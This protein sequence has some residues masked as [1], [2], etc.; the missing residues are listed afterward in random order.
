MDQD[1]QPTAERLATAYLAIRDAIAQ[2]NRAAEREIKKLKA[3]QDRIS[4][5]LNKLCDAMDCSSIKTDGGTVIRS[6]STRYWTSDW[7]SMYGFIQEE[8][9]FDL[10]ERRIHQKNIREYL[11]DNPDKMPKGVNIERSHKISVRKPAR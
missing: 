1:S 8:D 7:E 6:E 10:L 11:V 5:E 9:A 2:V 4:Q 3:D